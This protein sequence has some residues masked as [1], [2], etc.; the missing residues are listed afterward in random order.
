MPGHDWP[1]C[2]YRLLRILQQILSLV[3]CAPANVRLIRQSIDFVANWSQVGLCAP[4]VA[5]ACCRE[6]ARQMVGSPS[7]WS[8]DEEVR[9]PC[10]ADHIVE[11]RVLCEKSSFTM[12]CS[13]RMSGPHRIRLTSSGS[14]WDRAEEKCVLPWRSQSS[15][16]PIL[17]CGAPA[18]S[19]GIF[20]AFLPKRAGGGLHRIILMIN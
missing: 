20:S 15:V 19:S 3:D 17:I 13:S 9:I 5:L 7:I 10:A 16:A 12:R 4:F 8:T 14:G 2:S 1:W 6:E 11:K 18:R